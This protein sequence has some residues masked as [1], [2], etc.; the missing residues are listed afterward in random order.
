[1]AKHFLVMTFLMSFLFYLS[2]CKKSDD[3]MMMLIHGKWEWNP[4]FTGSDEIYEFIDLANCKHYKDD[5]GNV[6]LLR[7]DSLTINIFNSKLYI[8]KKDGSAYKTYTIDKLTH[9]MLKLEEVKIQ[10][11]HRLH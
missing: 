11:F 7:A 8:K 4:P 3:E 1:M 5:H 6:L 9:S 10:K 2:S